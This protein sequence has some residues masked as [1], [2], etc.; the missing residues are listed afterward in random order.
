MVGA[1]G[2]LA[3]QAAE[4]AVDGL[5]P[6]AGGGV[7]DFGDDVAARELRGF[8]ALLESFDGVE[9]GVSAASTGFGE[10]G[11]QRWDGDGRSVMVSWRFVLCKP[12]STNPL[13]N[14]GFVVSV[15]IGTQAWRS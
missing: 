10:L 6:E 13:L 1:A 15:S 7:L 2:F 12:K 14:S 8:G 11:L 5:T 3:G 9:D 4:A